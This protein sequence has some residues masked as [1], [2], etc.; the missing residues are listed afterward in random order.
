MANVEHLH[1]TTTTTYACGDF[2]DRPA[3]APRAKALRRL[4]GKQKQ[5]VRMGRVLLS[6]KTVGSDEAVLGRMQSI[7][8]EYTK[9]HD[10][11][12]AIIRTELL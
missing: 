6:R 4:E 3:S 2:W 1:P 8:R 10:A 5:A 11:L 9:Y 12:I 7:S